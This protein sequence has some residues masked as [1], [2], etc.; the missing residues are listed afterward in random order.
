MNLIVVKGIMDVYAH[1]CSTVVINKY[2]D[3]WMQ[4]NKA[5]KNLYTDY[6]G[7]KQRLFLVIMSV[8]HFRIITRFCCCTD[9]Y[10]PELD[11]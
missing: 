1:H 3:Y 6:D 4:G 5:L 9:K 8:I 10:V 7:W 11:C 2:V